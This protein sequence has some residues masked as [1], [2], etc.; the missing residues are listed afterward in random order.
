MKQWEHSS[1]G[2]STLRSDIHLKNI[3]IS[4]F[5]AQYS[6]LIR[7]VEKTKKPIQITRLGKPV[8]EIHPS[9]LQISADRAL[10]RAQRDARDLEIINRNADRLNAAAE[11]ALE[12]QAPV[13]RRRVAKGEE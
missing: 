8:A 11:D 13:R 7:G 6:A 10:A 2:P 5:R 9:S 4:E 3:S 12:Y 1:V